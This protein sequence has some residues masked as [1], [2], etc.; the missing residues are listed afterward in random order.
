V[1]VIS[2]FF[3]G[4]LVDVELGGTEARTLPPPRTRGADTQALN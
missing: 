4:E 1:V 3:S 2:L